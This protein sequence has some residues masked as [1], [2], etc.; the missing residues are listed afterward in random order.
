MH[1]TGK[2]ASGTLHNAAAHHRVGQHKKPLGTGQ[3]EGLHPWHAP[4]ESRLQ[5]LA[6]GN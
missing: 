2:N 4:P 6:P 1:A 3:S 5:V